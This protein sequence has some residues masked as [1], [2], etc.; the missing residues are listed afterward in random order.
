MEIL[1]FVVGSIVWI[2]TTKSV[3]AV[4][5]KSKEKPHKPTFILL[6]LNTTAIKNAFPKKL[7]VAVFFVY[8]FKP[9]LL[10]LFL[11]YTGLIKKMKRGYYTRKI[12]RDRSLVDNVIVPTLLYF[13]L[14]K[15]KLS[16]WLFLCIWGPLVVINL[17]IF[18]L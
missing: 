1:M 16:G 14:I 11:S 8:V 6:G 7:N 4:L 17:V 12:F 5:T 10:L 9:L 18:F 2:F 13:V 15:F 3:C